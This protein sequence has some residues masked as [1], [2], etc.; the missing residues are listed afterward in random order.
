MPRGS[1]R[2][3]GQVPAYP[4]TRDSRHAV[5]RRQTGEVEGREGGWTNS[6]L[7]VGNANLTLFPPLPVHWRWR[8]LASTA[9]RTCSADE[10]ALRSSAAS[11]MKEAL[12]PPLCFCFIRDA[13]GNVLR[14]QALS[15]SRPRNCEPL[16]RYTRRFQGGM[17]T[18]PGVNENGQR[19]WDPGAA[20]ASDSSD[21]IP[22]CFVKKKK[23]T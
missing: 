1:V 6:A 22:A 21:D 23:E 15:D 5:W 10:C 8:H 18:R 11:S 9:L 7:E 20:A 4:D 19:L 2:R 13:R 12:R 3:T 14:L 16:L 17:R